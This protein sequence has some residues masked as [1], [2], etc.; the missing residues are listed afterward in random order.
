MAGVRDILLS[1]LSLVEQQEKLLM[2]R[3]KEILRLQAE[4]NAVSFLAHLCVVI[5]AL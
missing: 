1:N 4:N 3:E 2:E 5:V